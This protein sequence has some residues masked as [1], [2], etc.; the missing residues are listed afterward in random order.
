MP[1]LAAFLLLF[2]AGE[3][4]ADVTVDADH[5]VLLKGV[6][7]FLTIRTGN[8]DHNPE[9][10]LTGIRGLE[11]VSLQNGAWEGEVIAE[12]P[13]S[14]SWGEKTRKLDRRVI[15]AWL[16]ILPPLLAILLAFLTRQ[17]FLSLFG[18]LW[19]GYI[20]IHGFGPLDILFAG[21]DAVESGILATFGHVEHGMILLFLLLLGGM[22]GVMTASG[23]TKGFSDALS[24]KIR[25]RRSG[26]VTTWFL[27]LAI[28]I[29]DYASSMTV[30]NAMRPL[31][32]R[33]RISRE[34]LS[35][36]VDSTAAPLASVGLAA[37]WMVFQ[38]H[39][40]SESDVAAQSGPFSTILQILPYSFYSIFGVI[41]VLLVALTQRDFGPMRKAEERTI[42]TGQVAGLDA[43]PL[44]DREVAEVPHVEN[45][46]ERWQNVAFPILGFIVSAFLLMYYSGI[47]APAR[48]A[49]ETGFL[50]VIGHAQRV[51]MIFWAS[52]IGTIIALAMAIFRGHLGIRQAIGAWFRGCRGLFL[53]SLVL[54]LAW[55]MA[56]L[57]FHLSTGTWIGSWID[58]LPG[59]RWLPAMTFLGCALISLF[60][61]SSWSTILIMA[62]IVAPIAWGHPE[63]GIRYGTI[64][65]VLSGSIFG[66]H[67]SPISNSTIVSSVASAADHIDHVKTQAPYGIVCALVALGCG[68]IP[69]GFGVSPL[70]C[71]PAGIVLLVA[72]LFGMGKKLR[73][74]Y[75]PA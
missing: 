12:G 32:D 60:T 9:V 35:Y 8:V 57:C 71:L 52:L 15:P 68:F 61:G 7:F 3:E 48:A 11:S 55:A 26:M 31:T 5:K 19:M 54:V 65:A 47:Q 56:Q 70:I 6:P 28:F 25:T 45:M 20:L 49:D 42:L 72:I 44:V 14:I 2:S 1:L 24:R 22:V 73:V 58:D 75:D 34:K 64:A 66:D 17:V 10:T 36:I 21:V 16:C 50:Q 38:S 18:G 23:G 13:V 30:G 39:L 63:M 74:E 51:R 67:I 33:L 27:S 4:P 53:P 46:P 41:F 59:G 62:G 43:R 29:N 69:A 40:G 37:T